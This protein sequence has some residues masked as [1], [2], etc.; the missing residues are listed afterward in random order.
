AM[1]PSPEV[2]SHDCPWRA[3]SFPASSAPK[4]QR[5]AS[6]PNR[7]GARGRSD[8]LRLAGFL[9]H[10]QSSSSCRGDP[11]S[12]SAWALG[13]LATHRSAEVLF[14]SIFRTTT[15]PGRPAAWLFGTAV[16]LPDAD[17]RWPFT[18]ERLS[19]RETHG[20]V[21]YDSGADRFFRSRRRGVPRRPPPGEG[22]R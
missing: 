5:G 3:V 11:L 6:P 8:P 15:S 21:S 20:R 19:R 4:V 10:A 1:T 16:A 13:P 14:Q 7:S 17:R 12:L 9:P 22:D 18:V 2:R